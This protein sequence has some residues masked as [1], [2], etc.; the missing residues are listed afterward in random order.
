MAKTLLGIETECS[1]NEHM[2]YLRDQMAK[3]LL[4]IDWS[5]D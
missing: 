1:M 4:G 2:E 5:L 3:T